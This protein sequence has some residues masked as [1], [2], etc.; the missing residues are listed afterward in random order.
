MARTFIKMTLSKEHW[1]LASERVESSKIFHN[2]HRKKEAN[3]VGFLGEV[4]LEDFFTSRGVKF[5]DDR[6]KTTHDYLINGS[7]TLDLKTKDRT[8]APTLLY[9]NSVPLYNHD[10]QR[11]DYYYFISL[12]RNKLDRSEDINRFTDAYIVGGI[13]FDS[14]EETG[15]HWKKDQVDMTNGTKFWTDCI[16]IS[17]EALINNNEM[18][19]ILTKYRAD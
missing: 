2:S 17:M 5:V 1:N 10:H 12:L 8:V 13:D 7:I 14:L 9:D 15:T 4:V 19:R 11:P 6:D 3:Q 16:N 18:L